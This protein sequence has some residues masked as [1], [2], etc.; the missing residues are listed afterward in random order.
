VEDETP[1]APRSSAIGTRIK[2]PKDPKGGE[3]SSPHWHRG[4]WRGLC[5]LSRKKMILDLNVVSFDAF[6]GVGIG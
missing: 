2:A 4:L 1:Q 5:P 3:G 6:C